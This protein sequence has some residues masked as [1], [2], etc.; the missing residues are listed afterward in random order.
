MLKIPAFKQVTNHYHAGYAH[1][2]ET[3]YMGFDVKC[4]FGK[5][6]YSNDYETKKT[7]V[8]LTASKPVSKK[9]IAKMLHEFDRCCRCE[10]D[11]CGHFNGGAYYHT[12][13]QLSRNGRKFAV[14]LSY[15]MNV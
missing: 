3:K 14:Q 2:N 1:L 4:V 7:W 10:H 9:C 8:Y 5:T 11:C 6:I 15:L 13:K 12:L